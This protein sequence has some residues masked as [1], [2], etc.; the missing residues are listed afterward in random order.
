M[1]C[2]QKTLKLIACAN[3]TD[4]LVVINYKIR[5]RPG[6]TFLRGD[7]KTFSLLLYS[8]IA[9]LPQSERVALITE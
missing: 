4:Q 3:F 6:E 5:E 2:L 1:W 9:L 8:I 7:N